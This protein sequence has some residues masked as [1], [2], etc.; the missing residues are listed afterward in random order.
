MGTLNK[1]LL[2]FMIKVQLEM[3]L[4]FHFFQSGGLFG[5]TTKPTFGGFGASSG[6]SGF[7]APSTFS[8]GG[9]NTAVSS[10]GGLFGNTA[11]KSTFGFGGAGTGF[12]A[13]T[14]GTTGFGGFGTGTSSFG[15]G[16]STGGLFGGKPL[17][18]GT[19]T[20]TAGTSLFGAAGI[21]FL[22]FII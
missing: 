17:G 22:C 9:N 18:F 11:N 21:S 1:S 7:S 8:F 19:T 5:T 6:T 20:N 12:G 13:N 15:G 3:L 2:L 4:P 10:G 14:T 16:T